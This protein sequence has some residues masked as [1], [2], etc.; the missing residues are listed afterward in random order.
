MNTERRAV[1]LQ[2]LVNVV[3][4]PTVLAK[5]EC[6]TVRLWHRIKKLLESLFI[7]FPTRRKLKKDWAKFRLQMICRGEE[8]IRRGLRILQL[9]HVSGKPTTLNSKDKT[10]WR[11]VTPGIDR[12]GRWQV[13]ERVVEFYSL[14][15][16]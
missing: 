5:L 4:Q 7:D 12:M 10:S 2:N 1:S 9:L 16:S 11:S 13:V 3:V 15:L 8:S 14:E 6:I